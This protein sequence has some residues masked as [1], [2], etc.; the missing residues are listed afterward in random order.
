MQPPTSV[1]NSSTH[2]ESPG[3]IF[4]GG[5]VMGELMR[6]LNWS[7]TPLG[8][9]E[10]WPQSLKTSIST[11]L[12]SR[13]AIVVWWG[14]EMVTLYNDSYRR[15]LGVK[16]PA[17]LGMRARDIWPEIWHIVGPMLSG[18]MER[19]EATRGDNLLLELERNGYQ[20]ECYF[21]FSYSPIRDES[22][23][24]GGIFTPVQETTDQVIGERRLRSLRDLAQAARAA[25]AESSE[26]VCRL[27]CQTLE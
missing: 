19:S 17:A 8:P 11:C 12:D 10:S 24:V 23:G 27:E 18:V 2:P 15:I 25:N 16:H 4:V 26:E 7:A 22:G 20:E 9:V 13:F 1:E 21:T 6:G 3:R 14:P 5:G